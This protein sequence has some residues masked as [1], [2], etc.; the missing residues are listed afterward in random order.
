MQKLLVLLLAAGLITAS[1]NN[2]KAENKDDKD[3]T[4]KDGTKDETKDKD[5]ENKDT[6]KT[7]TT[8]GWPQKDRDDFMSSCVREA[9]KNNND[10]P[11]SQRYCQ[12]ML[13]KMEAK[14]PDVNRAAQLTDQEIADV[15]MEYR[16]GCLK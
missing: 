11:L 5:K 4:E 9:V 12:C 3:K 2:K 13:E 6:E 1:C 15:M 7:T 14:Y 16:D 10:E 8:T